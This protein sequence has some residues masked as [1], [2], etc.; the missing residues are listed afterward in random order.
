V[1]LQVG[2]FIRKSYKDLQIT[3]ISL[4]AGGR[5]EQVFKAINQE[6]ASLFKTIPEKFH[7]EV[8]FAVN[9]SITTGK[10]LADLVPFLKRITPASK[11]TPSTAP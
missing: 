10:G 2:N 3:P 9:R 1:T 4:Q 5:H 11:T 8:A 6:A 7:D